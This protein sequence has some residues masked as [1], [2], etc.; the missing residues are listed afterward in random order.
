V[1]DA[2]NQTR[3]DSAYDPDRL[4]GFAFGMGLDRLAMVMWGIEDIRL[5]IENDVRF[6]AQFA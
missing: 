4:S 5:L 1:F 3:D 6:L 2:V